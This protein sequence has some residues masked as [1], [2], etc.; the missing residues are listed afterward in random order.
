MSIKRY[1]ILDVANQAKIVLECAQILGIYEVL[2]S[3]KHLFTSGETPGF[4]AFGQKSNVRVVKK[5]FDRLDRDVI[6]KED[7]KKNI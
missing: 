6:L 3:S 1:V 5:R 2:Y 4:N 7:V